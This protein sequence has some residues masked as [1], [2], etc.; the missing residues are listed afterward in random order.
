M[1]RARASICVHQKN[2]KMKIKLILAISGQLGSSVMVSR[3]KATPGRPDLLG[4]AAAEL[5]TLHCRA[6]CSQVELENTLDVE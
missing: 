5:Q 4:P 3:A 2:K 1:S 6:H